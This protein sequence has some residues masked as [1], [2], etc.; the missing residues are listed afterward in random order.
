MIA[1]HFPPMQGSSGIQRTLNFVRDLPA[2]GWLPAVLTVNARAHEKTSRQSAGDIPATLLVQRTFALDTAR[3]LSVFDRYPLFLA[4]P[5]RWITWLLGGIPAGLGMIRRLKPS[6]IWSTYP[7]ATA[8]LIGYALTRLSGIPWIA[9]FRDPM[10]HEGYPADRRTWLSFLRVE[11]KVFALASRIVFAS[12]GAA[13]FYRQRYPDAAERIR[14]IENGHDEDA[15]SLA[16]STT[17]KSPLNPGAVTLLHSGI[18]YPEWR[19]PQHLFQA[20]RN[21][22]DAGKLLAPQ[23]RLRF[24]APVHDAFLHEQVSRHG[25]TEIVEILPPLDY[26]SA[27]QEMLR[28]D[29]LLVLQSDGCNDQIPAKLYE[30]IRARRPIIG[31]TDPKGDTAGALRGAGFRHIAPLDDSSAIGHTL[32]TYL[33][34]LIAGTTPTASSDII[35]AASRQRRAQDLAQLLEEIAPADAVA[36]E[37]SSRYPGA[38]TAIPPAN[39]AEEAA[40]PHTS[41][42]D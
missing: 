27:L 37:I 28:A 18:V 19:D 25:L 11:Q 13:E 35:D 39:R 6:V 22:L 38:P 23:F 2:L 34:E 4:L 16:E 3:H 7:I 29:G 31:L 20:I 10:A 12:P 17:D 42:T 36:T 15:F 21:L 5:D 33:H 40:Q 24:R 26:R 30:Y 1:Y 32:E 14:V 8:H 9:D 41:R